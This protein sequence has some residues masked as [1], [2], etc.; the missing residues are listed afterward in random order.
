[1]RDFGAIR[2]S[3]VHWR[4]LFRLMHKGDFFF[5]SFDA[6]SPERL[7]KTLIGW[8]RRMGKLMVIEDDVL[9]QRCKVTCIRD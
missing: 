5:V 8:E 2:P 1:M 3:K 6:R 4:N 9:E 7:R